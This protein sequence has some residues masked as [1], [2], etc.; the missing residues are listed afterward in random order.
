M[1]NGDDDTPPRA[2]R[3]V[4]RW[5]KAAL[6]GLVPAVSAAALLAL[7]VA[8]EAAWAEGP[9]TADEDSC[10]Y[11]RPNCVSG[12]MNLRNDG[13][14]R[15]KLTNNCGGRIYLKYCLERTGGRSPYCGATGLGAG[16]ST[17]PAV[18]STYNA[19]GSWR[20]AWIGVLRDSKDWVCSHKVDLERPDDF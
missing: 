10:Y 11:T 5:L 8:P 15:L 3:R 2:P 18:T 16:N 12:D 4:P 17:W 14:G 9:G 20:I 6:R 13:E 19:T 7:A 1:S